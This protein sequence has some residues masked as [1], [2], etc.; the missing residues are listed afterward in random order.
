MTKPQHSVTVAH[1][2]LEDT[3]KLPLIEVAA[4]QKNRD[5]F[6][7]FIS[8]DGGWAGIDKA[9]AAALAKNGISVVGWNS[10]QYFWQARSPETASR[11][12][13]RIINH[14]KNVWKKD[15]VICIGYSFGA[16]V[17]PFMATRLPKTVF[18]TIPLFAFISISKAADF[19]FHLSDWIGG[20]P[21]KTAMPVLPELEKMKEKKTLYFFGSEEKEEVA[22]ILT[23]HLGKTISLPGGH[24]FRGHYQAIADSITGELGK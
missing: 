18:E 13:E 1:E 11:D 14:Y 24:H 20:G 8:G 19:Q 7:V 10:L 16:D 6:A 2:S 5:V 15:T 17:L 22:G 21:S 9:V 4:T 3:L 23:A 12:L